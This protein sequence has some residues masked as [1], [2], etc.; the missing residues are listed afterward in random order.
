MLE[1]DCHPCV[2]AMITLDQEYPTI[3]K[4]EPIA[5]RR[6]HGAAQRVGVEG[7]AIV[8][9]ELLRGND[10]AD[11]NRL[12]FA[13]LVGCPDVDEPVGLVLGI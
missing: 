4:A 3:G 8:I 9:Q 5:N 7:H 10:L 6:K 11:W 1:T 2:G 12:D 13:A